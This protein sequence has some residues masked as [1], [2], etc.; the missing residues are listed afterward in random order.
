MEEQ[1]F[2]KPQVVGS[3]PTAGSTA[4]KS[5]QKEVFPTDVTRSFED[6]FMSTPGQLQVNFGSRFFDRE[7]SLIEN[8]FKTEEVG[9]CGQ[10]LNP[11]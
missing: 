9:I 2:R 6:K 10:A 5:P 4:S 3:N 1:R 7:R 11:H 8:V